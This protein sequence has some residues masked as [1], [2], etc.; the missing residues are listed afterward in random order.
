MKAYNL[1]DQNHHVIFLVVAI[2]VMYSTTL[3]NIALVIFTL[4]KF[5]K[6]SMIYCSAV[7]PPDL[8]L[9]LLEYT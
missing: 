2:V 6:I 7:F 4:F 1:L 5:F 8:A 9:I 3:F